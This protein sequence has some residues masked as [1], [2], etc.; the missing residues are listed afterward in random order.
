[1]V[2]P[3]ACLS[4]IRD[5]SVDPRD[6]KLGGS[7]PTV[8][9]RLLD[10]WPIC[11]G[12]RVVYPAGG[13]ILLP[14]HNTSVRLLRHAANSPALTDPPSRGSIW[15]AHSTDHTSFSH[16][17]IGSLSTASCHAPNVPAGAGGVAMAGC[18]PE[19]ALSKQ[20]R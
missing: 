8:C 20:A 10:T 5:D 13:D 2:L 18:K 3:P 16:P 6:V 4:D 9:S 7:P 1:V 17:I 12:L 11:D 14:V 15:F 19:V